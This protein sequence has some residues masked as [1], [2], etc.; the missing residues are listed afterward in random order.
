MSRWHPKSMGIT[1]LTTKNATKH[2]WSEY[3][4]LSP[5]RREWKIKI[6]WQSTSINPWSKYF[7]SWIQDLPILTCKSPPLKVVPGQG[8][9]FD[10]ST[11]WKPNR[12]DIGT[13][14]RKNVSKHS[15]RKKSAFF[16]ILLRFTDVTL[17]STLDPC[18]LYLPTWMAIK[19]NHSCR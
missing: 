6:V 8:L 13:G 16:H 9:A 5:L 2:D 17:I 10:L 3:P 14:N 7:E 18:M 15:D 19:I 4:A 1:K 12:H 11:C